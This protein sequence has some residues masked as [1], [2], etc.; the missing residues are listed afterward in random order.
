MES[1]IWPSRPISIPVGLFHFLGPR[2]ASRAGSSRRQVASTGGTNEHAARQ[3]GSTSSVADRL[4]NA[5]GGHLGGRTSHRPR[6]TRWTFQSV[7]RITP[8]H[9]RR[10]DR[11]TKSARKPGSS[12]QRS[13]RCHHRVRRNPERKQWGNLP[14]WVP[15][16]FLGWPKRDR[17]D[18]RRIG[19]SRPSDLA[20]T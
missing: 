8:K 5:R 12:V 13:E 11:K 6:R 1:S 4:W 14:R 3:K 9:S 2:A 7:T 20:G 19:N 16:A 17:Q 10:F 15:T 18:D